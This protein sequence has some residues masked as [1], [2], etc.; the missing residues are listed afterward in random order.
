MCHSIVI[1]VREPTLL[2]SVATVALML[3]ADNKVI[4]SLVSPR[5]DARGWWMEGFWRDK[6]EVCFINSAIRTFKTIS[7]FH[8]SVGSAWLFACYFKRSY[9]WVPIWFRLTPL[10]LVQ[11]P[12]GTDGNQL[13]EH[14]SNADKLDAILENEGAM[15][16]NKPTNGMC[17]EGHLILANLKHIFLNRETKLHKKGKQRLVTQREKCPKYTS[18]CL[19][20]YLVGPPLQFLS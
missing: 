17:N 14:G 11:F 10:P 4:F 15:T 9:L 13:W 18:G 19:I 12:L 2:V 16:E 3:L 1:A 6:T 20:S 7:P 8:S 5:K